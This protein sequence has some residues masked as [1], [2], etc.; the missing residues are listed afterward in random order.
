MGNQERQSRQ[1]S[2]LIQQVVWIHMHFLKRKHKKHV[3]TSAERYSAKAILRT[4][5]HK[6]PIYMHRILRILRIMHRNTHLEWVWRWILLWFQFQ[7]L[8]VLS[9]KWQASCHGLNE[10]Q[11]GECHHRNAQ[12]DLWSQPQKNHAASHFQTCRDRQSLGQ[13]QWTQCVSPTK[14]K[15]KVRGIFSHLQEDNETSSPWWEPYSSP[16]AH[17]MRALRSKS[18]PH[19]RAMEEPRRVIKKNSEYY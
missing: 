18:H 11:E 2:M 5:I 10:P 13:T 4:R 17:L 8:N 12:W 6:R 3:C 14:W 15:T 7:S 9:W 16:T 1:Y 19:F